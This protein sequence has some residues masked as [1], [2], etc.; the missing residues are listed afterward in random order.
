[1]VGHN[2][3]SRLHFAGKPSVVRP[4][5]AMRLWFRLGGENCGPPGGLDPGWLCSEQI[6]FPELCGLA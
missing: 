4:V 2:A 5:T 6:I 3:N 1:M